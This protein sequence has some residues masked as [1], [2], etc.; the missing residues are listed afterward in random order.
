MNFQQRRS[1]FS[2][3]ADYRASF[4]V[5][6]SELESIVETLSGLTLLVFASSTFFILLDK[7]V[8]TFLLK[9]LLRGEGYVLLV[10]KF[11]WC[12]VLQNRKELSLRP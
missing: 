3:L 4:D 10:T 5:L 12:V 8:L 11:L 9:M 7:M 1:R 6:Q 2:R